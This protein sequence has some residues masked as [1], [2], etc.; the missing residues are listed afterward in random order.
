MHRASSFAAVP[1]QIYASFATARKKNKVRA[2]HLLPCPFALTHAPLTPPHSHLQSQAPHCCHLPPLT[3]RVPL[4]VHLCAP[5]WSQMPPSKKP[6]KA[7]AA[8]KNTDS[9]TNKDSRRT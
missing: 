6:K 7:A 5:L 9:P 8:A 3:S 4:G 2:L 1:P